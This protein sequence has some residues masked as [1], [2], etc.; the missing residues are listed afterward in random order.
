[1]EK[2]EARKYV[3]VRRLARS[4]SNEISKVKWLDVKL[5]V[6]CFGNKE[7]GCCQVGR[8]KLS[9]EP[10]Y[11]V[12]SLNTLVFRIITLEVAL[13]FFKPL[14]KIPYNPGQKSLGQYCNIHNFL[15][16]LGS[17]L[18]QC[19]VYEIFLQFSVPPPPPPPPIQS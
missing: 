1:M 5:T 7:H 15:S 16:F 10:L 2:S 17:L 19:I 11:L 6:W 3:Y 8:V 12:F 4:H 18:K 9:F 14:K 13:L